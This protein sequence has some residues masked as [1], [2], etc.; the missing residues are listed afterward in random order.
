MNGPPSQSTSQTAA[1]SQLP[2]CGSAKTIGRPSA[3]RR[4][5]GSWPVVTVFPTI[6]PGSITGSRKAS[7]Q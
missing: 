5:T 2:L 1:A 7:C 4:S 3:R 6:R